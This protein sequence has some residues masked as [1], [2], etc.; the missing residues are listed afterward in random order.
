MQIVPLIG[1]LTNFDNYDP[2]KTEPNY[3][4]VQILQELLR[5]NKPIKIV[6]SLLNMSNNDLIKLLCDMR[7][8]HIT[9]AFVDSPFVGEKSRERLF[10]KLQGRFVELATSKHGS[11]S[12]DAIWKVIPMKLKINMMEELKNEQSQLM[13]NNYGSGFAFRTHLQSFRKNKDSWVKSMSAASTAEK[14][15][16]DV[17]P[18]KKFKHDD[19]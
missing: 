6:D 5:F 14:F 2:E 1:S 15:I 10:K 8:C 11:R 16:E 19:S 13:S 9:D 12:L 4:G 17:I 3:L 18:K 7:G